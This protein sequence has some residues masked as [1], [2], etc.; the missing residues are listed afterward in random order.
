[1]DRD[2][3]VLPRWDMS[4]IYPGL[5]SEAYRKD[6]DEFVGWLDR[7]VEALDADGICGRDKES[8]SV[9][10]LVPVLEGYLQRT[11]RLQ[12]RYRTLFAYCHG[13]LST[14]TRH[15]QARKELNVLE[16]LGVRLSEAGTRF[17]AWV[18]PLEG[19]LEK[20]I[21]ASDL[22]RDHRY[23]LEESLRRAYRR[24][25]E[26]EETLASELGLS[27][28]GAWSRLHRTITSQ[29]EVPWIGEDG[30]KML[31][32]SRIRSLG[33]DGDESVR[34]KAY[35]VEVQAWKSHE[36][37]LAACLN[38]V[39][40]W[41]TTLTR[42][43]GWS[44]PLESALVGARIDR[45]ILEALLGVMVDARQV[46]ARYYATKARVLGK[47]KLAWWDLMAPLPFKESDPIRTFEEAGSFV[48]EQFGTFSPR[49]ADYAARAFDE[50]WVDAESR[51]G[52]VD[53]AFCMGLPERKESRI[54]V[55]YDGSFDSLMTVAHELGHGFHNEI[56][57]DFGALR[58]SYP[59]T[60]A[61][62]A[63]IFCETIVFRAAVRQATGATR[64]G[65]LEAHLL[66]SS[67][68]IIDIHSR[69]LFEERLF[70]ARK[71]SELSP[72]E[73]CSLMEEAQAETYGD[74]IDPRYRHRYTWAMKP[75]YYMEKTSFYNY[76]YAFGLLFGLGLYSIYE[77]RGSSFVEDYEAILMRT[78]LADVR[79]VA[80]SVGIDVADRS[81]WAG[82]LQALERAIEEYEK[83]AENLLVHSSEEKVGG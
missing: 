10:E 65:M 79:T 58:R 62:T 50:G 5:E 74:A 53:G 2:L 81:F 64:L 41:V 71:E 43:R 36:E 26:S 12:M 61:E 24:M 17:L 63:S 13:F 20:L 1:M 19:E 40:G 59:M 51:A 55:N 72:A 37:E 78:G 60:L 42:R 14:D 54:L 73:L 22:L 31:P 75:H 7:H 15:E 67:Q 80:R 21:T 23:F 4:K 28:A 32:M 83:E 68:V 6:R 38:G 30:E 33:R 52:K 66:G 47:E 29:I 16:K 70:A 77:E 49:L 11:D 27:S 9:D 48:V 18:E 25:S 69:F 3:G 82:G 45:E 44:D 8:H 34:R 39:K 35:K 57:R 76:P 56:L 46:F